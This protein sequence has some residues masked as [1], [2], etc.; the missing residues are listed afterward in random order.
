MV[1]HLLLVQHVACEHGELVE[2]A[3]PRAAA[4]VT[5]DSSPLPDRLDAADVGGSDHAHCDVLALRHRPGDVAPTVGAPSLLTIAP[6]VSLTGCGE[7]RPV[8][9][10]SLAPKSSPPSA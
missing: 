3:R 5:R 10:L 1:L 2:V 9:L 4:A 7:S 6:R 8:P